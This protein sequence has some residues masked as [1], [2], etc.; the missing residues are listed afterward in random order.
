[1]KHSESNIIDSLVRASIAGDKLALEAL[2]QNVQS[3]VYGLCLR[4]IWRQE[5]AEEAC[6]EILIK[7]VTHL[8]SF[9]AESKFETWVYRIATNHLIDRKR[10]SIEEMGLTFMAFESDLISDQTPPT[11]EEA[12]SP[13][14]ELQLE[15]IRIGCTLALL[16]CLDREHR[17]AYIL[18]EIL[19]LDHKEGSSILNISSD[20]YRKRLER[21][22][23]QVETFTQ[24]V[25]GVL[26]PANP[27]RCA[28]RL[29]AAKAVGRIKKDRYQFIDRTETSLHR[30]VELEVQK[31]S[32]ARRT[33]AHYRA[34]LGLPSSKN[35]SKFLADLV[36]DFSK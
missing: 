2:I 4:M 16:Q 36:T 6:Q 35:F 9:K 5:E 30:N 21:A 33:A 14:F 18:G 28:N 27:C 19:E 20:A 7:I 23:A 29:C 17:I 12:K 26:S 3:K 10:A 32:L 11:Q 24:R 31:L 1:M 34:S 13:E 15:E 25:C 8:S 22:R